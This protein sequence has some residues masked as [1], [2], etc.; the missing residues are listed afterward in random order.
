MGDAEGLTIVE[1]GP[2]DAPR[3]VDCV[4]RAWG[5][6]YQD[7]EVYD[8]GDLAARLRSQM[9]R[10]VGAVAPDGRVV[11]HMAMMKRRAGDRT[12]DAGMT[13]VD[14]AFRGHRLSERLGAA[15]REV[16]LADGMVAY[17]HYPV[18]VNT[19]T[20]RLGLAA[21]GVEVGFLF[22][23]L[24]EAAT[25]HAARTA[26][27]RRSASLI[28][29]QPLTADAPERSVHLPERY[30]DLFRPMLARAGLDRRERAGRAPEP[31]RS[32]L[33]VAH[34]PVRDRR[35]VTVSVIGADLLDRVA[36]LVAD[37][38]ASL[39]HIDLRLDDPAAP[40]ASERL[41]SLGVFLGGLL[42]EYAQGDV[43]R[44]QHVRVDAWAQEPPRLVSEAGRRL[45]DALVE[46][47]RGVDAVGADAAG[48]WI[49]AD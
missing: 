23:H 39:T 9:L 16:M 49:A 10:S 33:E 27:T 25:A 44:L 41:R 36:P 35:L 22:A 13:I 19:V 43:V 2:D 12:S 6:S 34:D 21:G 5:D 26:T 32:G 11:G 17:H 40:W 29:H 42:P 47:A 15:L 8:V 48:P 1:L 3:L 7:R 14:P 31:T 18:T 37:D 30:V 46:D 28:L 4:R 38:P 24:G 20:Q 45:W